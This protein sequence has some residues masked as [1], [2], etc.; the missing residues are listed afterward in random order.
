M[1]VKWFNTGKV[2]ESLVDEVLGIVN[3]YTGQPVNRDTLTNMQI[4]IDK[5]F[6]TLPG[7]WMLF[8]GLRVSGAQLQLI[9]GLVS[10][11]WRTE[12]YPTQRHQNQYGKVHPL[13][14]YGP[15]DLWVVK[16]GTIPPV[17]IVRYGDQVDDYQCA[18]CAHGPGL[19]SEELAEAYRRAEGVGVLDG[20][21]P[22]DPYCV[23]T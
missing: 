3:L 23:F 8:E 22:G 5:L 13:G 14:Y 19:L 10:F 9:D 4:K 12:F 20:S 16:Q 17:L 21:I 18:S 11:H 2:P 15:H 6:E 1:L 7:Q